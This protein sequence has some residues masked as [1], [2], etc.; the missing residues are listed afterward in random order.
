[1]QKKQD[2]SVLQTNGSGVLSFSSV[3]TEV[4]V[5]VNFNG[6]GTPAIRAS[7]NVSSITDN[8]TGDFTINFTNSLTDANFAVGYLVGDNSS[9]QSAQ[10]VIF[11]ASSA[12]TSSSLRFRSCLNNTGQDAPQD[13]FMNTFIITR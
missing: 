8:G 4:K 2:V 5:W 6:T 1:L 12:M 10:T 3:S 7:K 13:Y 9:S 11:G